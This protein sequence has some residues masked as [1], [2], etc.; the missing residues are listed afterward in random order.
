VPAALIETVM[1]AV[2]LVALLPRQRHIQA[3]AASEEPS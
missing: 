1:L 3:V 2:I